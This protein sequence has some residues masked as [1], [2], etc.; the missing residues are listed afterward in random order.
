[1]KILGLTGDIAAGKST[2][3]QLLEARGASLL[4]ADSGVRELYA[5]PAFAVGVAAKFGDE[6]AVDLAHLSEDRR[7]ALDESLMAVGAD[8]TQ[9]ETADIGGKGVTTSFEEKR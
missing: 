6:V 8:I 4:D 1:M 9:I 5:L 2:V 7:R 3:A